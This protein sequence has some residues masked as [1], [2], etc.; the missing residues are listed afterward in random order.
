MFIDIHAG[1]PADPIRD[2]VVVQER[3]LAAREAGAIFDPLW[4]SRL[5]GTRLIRFMDW[6]MTS[7]ST[8]A[9]T[10]DRPRPADYTWTRNGVPVEVQVALANA[11]GADPWFN[12]PHLADDD[13]IRACATIV[14]DRLDP[15]LVAHVELSDEVW[16]RQFAQ[17]HRAERRGLARWGGPGRLHEYYALRATGMGRIWAEVCG[18]AADERL[19]RVLATQT[20]WH[21]IEEAI[22]NAPSWAAEGDPACAPPGQEADACAITGYFSGFLGGHEKAPIVRRWIDESHRAAEAEAHALGLTGAA[23]TAHVERHRDD[24]A[25]ALAAQELADGSET[26]LPGDSVRHTVEREF[27]YHAAGARRHGL[28]LMMYEGEPMSSAMAAGS[29]TRR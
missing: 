23:W 20:G 15:G 12:I 28:R 10:A 21:G 22:L 3:N 7:E 9:T 5:R 14:R 26:R 29:R 24:R 17:A 8:L 4:L 11:L 1:D 18:E 27:A 19:V 25:V 13:L 16:N 2:I 6:S